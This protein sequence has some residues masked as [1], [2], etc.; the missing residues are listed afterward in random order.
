[1]TDRENGT[2]A[3]YRDVS[4]ILLFLAR[5]AKHRGVELA[6]ASRSKA[7]KHWCPLALATL[8]LF[9]SSLLPEVTDEATVKIPDIIREEL[10]LIYFEPLKEKHFK[11]I[12]RKISGVKFGDMI[13]FDDELPNINVAKALGMKAVRLEKATGLMWEAFVSGL[14]EF[15]LLDA[16]GLIQ[17]SEAIYEFPVGLTVVLLKGC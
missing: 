1:M 10:R 14:K 12:K 17:K 2:I 11:E 16:P 5:L 6:I 3:I 4:G 7:L 15:D 13:L 8:P 9:S